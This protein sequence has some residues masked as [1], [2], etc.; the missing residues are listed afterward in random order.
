MLEIRDL[1]SGYGGAPVLRAL[2]LDVAPGEVVGL[3]GRNGAGKTT[4]LKTI[5]GLIKASAGSIRFDGTEL[6][7][8][9][10]HRIPR[11]GIG[12]VPQGRRLFGD[13][14]VEENLRLGRSVRHAGQ[15]TPDWIF[16]LFPALV[17]RL[18]QR[19]GSLSGGEQQM[20]AVARALC[21]EPRLL[22]MDEPTEGLMPSMIADI[23]QAVGALKARGVAV[24]FVEQK[25]EAALSVA[26]RNAFIENGAIQEILTT[27]A[28][29]LDAAPLRRYIGVGQP[30]PR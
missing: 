21:L 30:E 5:M 20:L 2:S 8:L 4:A 14:T 28:L 27:E 3:L 17:E 10:A 23:L 29:R 16:A 9:A 18:A 25:V 19:S 6:T 11:L 1:E 13:L 15:P 12:Y 7:G 26:D 24:V 22:L